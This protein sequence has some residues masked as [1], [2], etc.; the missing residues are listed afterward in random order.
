MEQGRSLEAP[1]PRLFVHFCSFYHV[2]SGNSMASHELRTARTDGGEQE[3]HHY[4]RDLVPG[5]HEVQK[6]TS[7]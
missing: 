2:R 7:G 3:A 4:I 5:I 6:W 1:S